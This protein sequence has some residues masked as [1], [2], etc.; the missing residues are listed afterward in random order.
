MS[1]GCKLF[2]V[3]EVEKSADELN[4]NT[5]I[6]WSDPLDESWETNTERALGKFRNFGGLKVY[7][8]C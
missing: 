4:L 7:L 6:S 1:S 3:F 5:L 2:D 8:E